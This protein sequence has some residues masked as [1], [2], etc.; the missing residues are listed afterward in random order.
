MVTDYDSWRE[1]EEGVD[2]A[3]VLRV[4][5]RNTQLAR[6]SCASSHGSCPASRAAS[7]IDTALDNA[8]MTAS[9]KRDHRTAHRE[10]ETAK[11]HRG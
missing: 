1:A 6:Q 10:A 8:I 4:M 3:D 5:A 11:A 9:D 7:P 2:A